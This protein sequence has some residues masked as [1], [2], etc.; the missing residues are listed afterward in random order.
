[1]VNSAEKTSNIAVKYLKE[2]CQYR[3]SN[4]EQIISLGKVASGQFSGLGSTAYGQNGPQTVD[5]Y[6]DCGG[7]NFIQ[8]IRASVFE[9]TGGNEAS[10]ALRRQGV[11]LNNLTGQ[12][13]AKG[14]GVQV[15]IDNNVKPLG[16][17][18]PAYIDDETQWDV[19]KGGGI[20]KGV[21]HFAVSGRYYQTEPQ[22]REGLIQ[23]TAGFTLIYR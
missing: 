7:T 18:M 1:M 17:D 23:T 20:I 16:T 19:V 22:I 11:L 5:V 15:L 4:R 6:I 2:S 8:N 12:N 10:A 21:Y 9:G 14:V 3:F 13:A